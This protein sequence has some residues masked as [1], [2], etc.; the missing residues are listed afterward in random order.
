M[1]SSTNVLD[2][3]VYAYSRA[4]SAGFTLEYLLLQS[5][6]YLIPSFLTGGSAKG[7]P[8][9]PKLDIKTIQAI[10]AELL[11]L[12]REDSRHMAQGEYPILVVTPESPLRHFTRI[13]VLLADAFSIHRRRA[14]GKTTEFDAQARDF[15]SELPRYYRRNFHFQTS[16][17]LSKRSAEVYEHQ[18]ELLFQGCADAM[19]RLILS[20][21]KKRFGDS[22]GEGLRFLEIGAGTGRAT[23]FV[24]LT[25]PKAKIIAVDL[26]DPYLKVAQRNLSGFPRIDF[27]QGDGA[28]LPFKDEEFDAVYS[29]FLFHELPKAARE[30]VISESLRVLKK[31]GFLGLVDSL[32]T[33]DKKLFDPL[34]Q[35]FPKAFH[36]PFYREYISSP[37]EDLLK[38]QGFTEI[39]SGTGFTSKVCTALKRS[40]A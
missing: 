5:F 7:M 36:E 21:L 17:Y 26:S 29:V 40:T 22:D 27:M 38:K 25:F 33:G 34:L 6:S 39:E 1:K 32:Q 28:H 19:R 11:D 35:H 37:M 23:R 30:E 3:P 12:L 13:P 31:D 24:H 20:R 16:G 18:V 4:R 2:L 14:R 10:R 9:P 8:K 15:L